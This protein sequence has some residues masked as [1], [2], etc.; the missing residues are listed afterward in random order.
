MK[1]FVFWHLLMRNVVELDEQEDGADLDD[2]LDDVAQEIAPDADDG[3]GETNLD[4]SV[5]SDTKIRE[6]HPAIIAMAIL[7]KEPKI[8][9]TDLAKRVGVVKGTLYKR[10][11]TWKGVRQ[12][13]MAR[14]TSL[15][16]GKK[17]KD[18]NIE[19]ADEYREHH[20]INDD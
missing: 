16:K 5:A 6:E 4:A 13:L 3:E 10:N 7:L 19:A 17:D 11:E 2:F 14:D 9:P 15:P 8:S 18:G 1:V 12:T 20:P